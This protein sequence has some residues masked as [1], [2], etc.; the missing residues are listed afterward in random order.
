MRTKRI[1]ALSAVPALLVLAACNS[2]HEARVADDGQ[3]VAKLPPMPYRILVEVQQTEILNQAQN[4]D[5]LGF[6]LDAKTFAERIHRALRDDCALATA[7]ATAGAVE[8]GQADLRLRITPK[9]RP[10]MAYEGTTRGNV[11]AVAVWL[12][13]IF[14]GSFIDDCRYRVSMP[15]NCDLIDAQTGEVLYQFTA[16]AKYVDTNYWERVTVPGGLLWSLSCLPHCFVSDNV[17]V[18]SASLSTEGTDMLAFGIAKQLKSGL[19][20]AAFR[21]LGRVEFASPDNGATLATADLRLD[22]TIHTDDPLREVQVYLG[23]RAERPLLQLGEVELR[24][25]MQRETG[26]Y[27]TR[28]DRRLDASEHPSWRRG[29]DNFLLL[30]FKAGSIDAT[31]T[32]RLV[33]N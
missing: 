11:A 1:R 6:V 8:P 20:K 25:M 30:R 19:D 24:P 32:L 7:V 2:L 5:Q 17:A 13:T 3:A 14:G 33:L 31:R 29:G 23:S 15:M 4:P 21:K 10:E 18:T 16:D 28:I 26:G 22:C 27:V 12:F 9:Q